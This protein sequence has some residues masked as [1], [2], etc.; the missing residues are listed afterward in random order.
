M[1]DEADDIVTSFDLSREEMN[2]YKTVKNK[3]G[4]HFIAR[5]NIIFERA[6]FNVRFQN[7]GK[8]VKNFI[9]NLHC[10]AKHC[11]FGMLKDELI[12]DGIVVRHKNKKLSKKLQLNPNLT[13]KK[14]TAQ[15][16]QSKEVKK[17]QSII[18]KDQTTGNQQ[19]N[20]DN[21]G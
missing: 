13:L 2:S 10:L 11:K 9:T 14:A 7:E 6:K 1:G 19:H 17:Q 16:R 21:V 15:A 20:I 3:F 5:R 12:Q 4:G 18:H 8:P